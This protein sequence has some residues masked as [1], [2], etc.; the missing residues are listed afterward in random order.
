MAMSPLPG[1]SYAR[2]WFDWNNSGEPDGTV[3]GVF[4]LARGDAAPLVDYPEPAVGSEVVVGS[5]DCWFVGRV[6]RTSREPEWGWA[7]IRVDDDKG[8]VDVPDDK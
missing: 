8:Q 2:V 5:E 6:E 1:E 7:W 4:Y 3:R